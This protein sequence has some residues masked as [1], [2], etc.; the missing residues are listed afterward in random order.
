MRVKGGMSLRNGMWH[1]LRNDIVMWNV[2]YAECLNM[3]G[4]GSTVVCDHGV[5]SALDHG[6][7]PTMVTKQITAFY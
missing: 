4:Q 6:I 7:L 3:V 2:I 1:G 5:L